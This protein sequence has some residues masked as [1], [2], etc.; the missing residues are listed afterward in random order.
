MLDQSIDSYLAALGA[1]TSTPGGGAVAAVSGSQ[2]AALIL[3][4]TEFSG[5]TISET[6][7]LSLLKIANDAVTR[8]IQLAEEDAKNFAALMASYKARSGIQDA[9]KDAARPPLD[10]LELSISLIPSLELLYEKGNP[11]LITDTGIAA[12]LLRSTIESSELNVLVNLRSIKDD[13]Y[14]DHARD[15]IRQAQS[16]IPEL[17]AIVENVKAQLD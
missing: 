1:K 11:N 13:K 10:C 15:K 12:S 7:R 3:M 8:F 5:K 2:A 14:A 17:N 9:L 16:Q 6:E 4:V